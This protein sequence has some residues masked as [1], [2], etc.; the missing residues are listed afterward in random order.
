MPLVCLVASTRLGG[1][2]KLKLEQVTS[3][4]QQ[5]CFFSMGLNIVLVSL[6]FSGA[7]MDL[8]GFSIV[9]P[10]PLIF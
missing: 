7:L 1:D 10:L 6:S 5:F 3:A 8:E 9:G 4:C 2:R